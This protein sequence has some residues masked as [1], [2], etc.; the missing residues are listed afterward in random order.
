MNNHLKIV[1]MYD[2]NCLTDKALDYIFN[3]FNE[4]MHKD[5]FNKID[6]ILSQI[7][8]YDYSVDMLVGFLV[9][10]L[11]AKN[12]LIN[13]KYLYNQIEKYFKEL[14]FGDEEFL[15]GLE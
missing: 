3:L 8:V 7:K 1:K 9:A 12:K 5:E 6:E 15:S 13:R 2:L 14:S 11:P 4:M 10:S